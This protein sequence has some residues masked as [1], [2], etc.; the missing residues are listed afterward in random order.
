M[1]NDFRNL[2]LGAAALVAVAVPGAVQASDF[3]L[4]SKTVT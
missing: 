4:E 2:L 1:P 3:T